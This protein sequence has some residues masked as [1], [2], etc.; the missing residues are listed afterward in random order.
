[1]NNIE[2]IILQNETGTSS[3]IAYTDYSNERK[4]KLKSFDQT[5]DG[6]IIS[7]DYILNYF[8]NFL[9]KKLISKGKPYSICVK[10][11]KHTIIISCNNEDIKKS[12]YDEKDGFYVF[13][14]LILNSVKLIAIKHFYGDNL[15]RAQYHTRSSSD[16][17]ILDD[18]NTADT[19][20][21]RLKMYKMIL[22][23]VLIKN[24]EINVSCNIYSE[25]LIDIQTK[26]DYQEEK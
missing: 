12:Y 21:M 24:Y 1:M 19:K 15:D 7:R 13:P 4:F 9:D 10:K 14:R 6:K 5:S 16:K 23:S 22:D 3:L 17:W 26:A 20:D 11:L 18:Y 2:T 25:V 8:C